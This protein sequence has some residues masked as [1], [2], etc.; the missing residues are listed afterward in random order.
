LHYGAHRA[1]IVANLSA[2]APVIDRCSPNVIPY[3]PNVIP[4]SPLVIPHSPLVIPAKAGNQSGKRSACVSEF[5]SPR[6]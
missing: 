2:S 4:Y 5:P 1:P 6:E 3:S